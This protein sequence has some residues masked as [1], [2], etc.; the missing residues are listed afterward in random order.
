MAKRSF[1][2]S[3]AAERLGVSA[4]TLRVYEQ[5][6]LIMPMRSLA[7]W[8]YYRPEDINAAA[9]IIAWRNLGLS[10]AEIER[11]MSG[12]DG[13][14]DAALAVHEETLA[15]KIRDLQ[16]TA[17]ELRRL[18]TQRCFV[19]VPDDS[20]PSD[21]LL[22]SA[23]SVHI[24][25]P[26]PWDGEIFEVERPRALNFIVGPLA[27][28]K[29]RLAECLADVLPDAA[30]VGLERLAEAARASHAKIADDPGLRTRVDAA[31]AELAHDGAET[32][33]ALIAVVA[34][35][36]ADTP[37]VVIIDLIEKDL[38]AATQ[39]ALGTYLHRRRRTPRPLF[40]MT[41][42]TAILNLD[43]VDPDTS[44]IFCPP[45]HSPPMYVA[46]FESSPGYEAVRLCL[47]EPEVRKR[48]DGV[49]AVYRPA[50]A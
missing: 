9:R 1:T 41:R 20:D 10:L 11:I 40:V 5:R 33:D 19:D 8:R 16:A 4:K 24:E 25:L 28:G 49:V 42:S 17:A 18:R 46:P 37:A 44:I 15:D 30:F 13:A 29:T 38:T 21:P 23:A 32:S 14:L 7:G 31:L 12:G 39:A 50:V 43:H 2:A 3:Q 6:G 47:A 45:N 27:S 35:L 36:E 34:S 48:T 26:W 22:P